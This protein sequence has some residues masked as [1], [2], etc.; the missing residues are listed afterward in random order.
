MTDQNPGFPRTRRRNQFD[1][2]GCYAPN[3]SKI[4]LKA[5][6]GAAIVVFIFIGLFAKLGAAAGLN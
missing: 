4:P 1:G 5:W 2:R 3:S 6:V